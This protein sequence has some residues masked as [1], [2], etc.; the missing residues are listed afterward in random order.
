MRVQILETKLI[1]PSTPP[2]AQDQVLPLSH[3]D[4]DPNLDVTFRY[5]RAYVNVDRTKHVQDPYHVVAG[6]LSGALP[7]YYPLCGTLRRD[8][9]NDHRRLELHCAAG[10][11]MPLVHATANCT[12]HAVKNLDDADSGFLEKLIPDPGPEESLVN[13][14]MLQV[15]VFECGGFSL[16]AAIHHAMC[17]GLGA[18]LFFGAAA[19][20]ARGADRVSIE[21]VWD[22][23]VL[24]GPRNPARVEAPVGDYLCEKGRNP[25]DD[26][27]NCAFVREFFHVREEWLD[28]LKAFL[29]EK[30]GQR[31]TTFEALGAFIWRAKVKVSDIPGDETVKFSYSTNIRKLLK[32]PLPVGYWGNGCVPIYAQLTAKDLLQKPIWEIAELIRKS[33]RN[34]N[35]EYVRSYIDFQE[36]H[37]R[38]GASAGKNVSGFTDWRHLGHSAVDFGWGGPANVLPLSRKL[39]GSNEAC[40]FLPRSEAGVGDPS[41]GFRVLANLKGECL[42]GFREE[43]DKLGKMEFGFA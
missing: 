18:T 1:Q 36:M 7:Y 5:L 42:C 17:D 23:D 22:R 40:F 8:N 16:G 21:P 27:E 35:D 12:L 26:E 38:E 32:P 14:C 2:L 37:R 43:M 19:E 34:A 20:L 10:Q 24:L 41:D 6:A 25:Y 29:L 13:P 9:G 28:R 15:T 4:A 3:L 11:G 30:C 31:F 39:L 33:K